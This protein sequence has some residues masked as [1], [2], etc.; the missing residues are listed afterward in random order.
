MNREIKVYAFLLDVILCIYIATLI[1]PQI[2]VSSSAT[3]IGLACCALWFV[4]SVLYAPQYYKN[5]RLEIVIS[6]LYAFFTIMIPYVFG[7]SVIA[8]RYASMVFIPL[9]YIIYDYYSYYRKIDRLIKVI[10]FMSGLSVFTLFN[11]LSALTN[12]SYVIRS[13]KSSGEASKMLLQQGVGDYSF[14]YY[15]VA[16]SIVFLFIFFENSK[17]KYKIPALCL[18]VLSI[19]LIVKSNYM[20]AL[21]ISLISS[22][23]LIIFRS[24]YRKKVFWSIIIITCLIVLFLNLNSIISIISDILP[25]RVSKVLMVDSHTSVIQSIY[26]E[27]MGDRWP[28]MKL[29]IDAF[30]DN[31]LFGLIGNQTLGFDGQYLDGLGQHSHI[32][33]TFAF[34][35]VF[36]GIWTVYIISMPF[37][38]KKNSYSRRTT[39]LNCSMMICIFSLFL[40]NNATSSIACVSGL[41]MPA[42]KE[43]YNEEY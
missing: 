7:Y 43:K 28:T 20:T 31:F 18:Y 30:K 1:L 3:V 16:M 40:F 15:I 22:V 8:H 13:I 2:R 32:L 12:N 35:G 36:I 29:S 23:L 10:F 26:D 38:D 27:F 39:A 21:L 34:Y 17:M 14:V 42:I 19:W 4:I 33:D 6:F 11:T 37:I 24:V 5:M 9:S 25:E 41:V